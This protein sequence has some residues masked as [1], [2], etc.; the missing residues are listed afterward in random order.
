MK[1]KRNQR[2]GISLIL[3]TKI[4]NPLQARSQTDQLGFASALLFVFE[5]LHFWLFCALNLSVPTHIAGVKREKHFICNNLG[6]ARVL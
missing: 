5:Q 1:T 6:I 4:D 2:L 3:K